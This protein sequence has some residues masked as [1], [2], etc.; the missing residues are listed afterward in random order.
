MKQINEIDL[1]G[2]SLALTVANTPLFLVR[3]LRND[4][5]IRLIS[6]GFSEDQILDALNGLSNTDP[7]EPINAVRPYV[8]LTALWMKSR[9]D[10]LRKAATLNMSRWRWYSYISLVLL[11][12]YSPIT[13]QTLP[14]TH[15]AAADRSATLTSSVPASR[16]ILA[17]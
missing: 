16:I 7:S 17:E 2:P 9:S 6:E 1:T 3:K 15:T 12:T 13:T 5:A 11:D 10:A 14:T 4:P 8:Y